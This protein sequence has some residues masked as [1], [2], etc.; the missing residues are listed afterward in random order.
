MRVLMTCPDLASR[1][2]IGRVVANWAN[3]LEQRPGWT[4]AASALT[5]PGDVLDPGVAFLPALGWRR[6]A[7]RVFASRWLRAVARRSAARVLGRFRPDVVNVHYP[8]YDRVFVDLRDTYGY[9]VVYSYHNVTDPTLYEG[10]ERQRRVAEDRAIRATIARCDLVTTNSHFTAAKL[11]SSDG[12]ACAVVWPGVDTAAFAPVERPARKA[13]S[14]RLIHVGRVDRHKGVHLLLDAFGL[15][16]RRLPEARLDIVGRVDSGPYGAQ[17]RARVADMNG[18]RLRGEMAQ[19]DMA[20]ALHEADLFVC[21]SL[22]E[23]YGLPFLEAQSTGL[24]CVGFRT[25]AIPEVVSDGATGRLVA[26]GDASGLADAV[27]E[28]AAD[29]GLRRRLSGAAVAWARQR[30]WQTSAERFADAVE[31]LSDDT[32]TRDVH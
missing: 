19:P 12:P 10:A 5:G 4:V 21:A 14:I 1:A 20:V 28:L 25:A 23:G 26:A 16:R 22:F 15:V 27:A 31:G 29:D 11:A 32:G 13:A 6:G 30:T 18:V 2:G 8:P 17:I 7:Y 3:A 9:R 24:P